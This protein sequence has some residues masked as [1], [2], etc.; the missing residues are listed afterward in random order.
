MDRT[1]TAAY[2]GVTE[3]QAFKLPISLQV[4]MCQRAFV[5]RLLVDRH[6]EVEVWKF[7]EILLHYTKNICQE[8][9]E[10]LQTQDLIPQNDYQHF[11]KV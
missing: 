2:T 9:G 4:C 6:K 11:G 7:L 5:H 3:S 1:N 10:I 8:S